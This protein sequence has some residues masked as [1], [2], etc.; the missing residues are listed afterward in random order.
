MRIGIIGTGTV[1]R[2]LGSKLVT[3]GHE[4]MLGSRTRDNA[5]AAEWVATAGERASQGTFADAA[6]FGEALFNCTGGMVSLQALEAAGDDNLAGKVLID[7]SNPLDFSHGMPPTLSVCNTDSIAEQI[8]RRFPRTH[9]VK[10]LNTLT[11]ALMVEPARVPGPHDV[12]VCGNDEGARRQV[13][14]WLTEW[15][16]WPRPRILDLG[17]ITAARGVEMLLP[18]W[19]RLYIGRGTAMFNFHIAGLSA[20]A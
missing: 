8:Q 17:D 14:G 15:F 18:L 4:V 3:R 11:A 6:A 16:D 19:L 9:V 12:F 5:K 7:V 1:G 13:A 2:T 10:S 20:G